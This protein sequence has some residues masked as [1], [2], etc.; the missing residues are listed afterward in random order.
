MSE[1][2][3]FGQHQEISR[4]SNGGKTFFFNK[5]VSKAGDGYLAINALYGRGNQE[6]IVVFPSHYLQF[7]KAVKAAIEQLA[8]V[9]LN[10]EAPAEPAEPSLPCPERCPNCH[11]YLIENERNSEFGPR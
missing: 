5:G 7:F 11:W 2:K 9:K 6:R 8:E 1:A 4:F 10:G 3:P